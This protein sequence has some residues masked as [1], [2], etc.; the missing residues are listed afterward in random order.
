LNHLSNP[1]WFLSFC[2]NNRAGKTKIQ[3]CRELSYKI[4]QKRCQKER[5][6]KTILDYIDR[7][8]QRWKTD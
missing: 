7:Q 5:S 6:A 1:D 4:Q 8:L 3:H 2:G